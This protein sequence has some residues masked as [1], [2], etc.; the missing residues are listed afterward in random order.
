MAIP[1]LKHWTAGLVR[2]PWQLLNSWY[3]LFFQIPGLSDY[4]VRH[5]DF[6]G[7]EKLMTDW[8]ADARVSPK[9]LK[10][11]KATFSVGSV[12]TSAV[13]YYRANIFPLLTPQIASV[14]GVNAMETITLIRRD[15]HVPMLMIYG[16]HDGCIDARM[17]SVNADR[18]AA[19]CVAGLSLVDVPDAGHF[20]HHD[21]PDF[22]SRLLLRFLQKT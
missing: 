16:H 5:S 3:M 2:A 10:S 19:Q 15:L 7:V 12:A 21:K 14:Y 17:F 20:L 13:D 4:W 6:A 9:R 18:M 1:L 11:V 22:V 8:S